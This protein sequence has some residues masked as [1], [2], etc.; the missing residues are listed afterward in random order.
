MTAAPKGAA[1]FCISALFAGLRADELLHGDSQDLGQGFQLHVGGDP[2]LSFQFGQAGGIHV[3]AQQ[4]HFGDKRV[5]RHAELFRMRST[6][7]PQIFFVP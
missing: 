2:G 3:H 5:L 6:F 1:V 4:L 7:A